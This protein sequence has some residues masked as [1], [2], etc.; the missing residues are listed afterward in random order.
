MFP[1]E[2]DYYRPD[3]V[4]EAL[5]VLDERPGAEVLAGGHSLIPSMKTGLASPGT[6]V[7]IG[8]I[9]DL[10]GIEHGERT[11]SLG[12]LTSY[13]A[14]HDD[15]T[16]WERATV[17][18]EAA[19]EIGDVQ[20]RNRGTIGGNVAHA[21]PASDL[22]GAVLAADATLV[23]AGPEGER[24]IPAD[25]FFLGMYMT[26]VGEDE[27][28]TGVRVPYHGDDTASA[29]VKRPSPSS[30][31]A[32]VGVAAVLD[33]DGEVIESARLAANGV[34]GRAVRL[35]PTEEALEGVSLDDDGAL[36]EAAEFAADD[37]DRAMMM[38]DIHASGEFRE[39][40]LR[41]YTDRALAAAVERIA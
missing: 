24:E 5:S 33:T 11:A 26:D 41:I 34:M 1:D 36:T 37:L 3:T 27:L 40:L 19:G 2:F 18:A 4:E 21:D 13:A 22:P 32:M 31:Y 8:R 17:V 29:Y 16:L 28:L 12:A 7:D 10:R 20:V 6:L 39:G 9:E 30:G 35:T 25:E 38:D 23:V 14:V 15:D